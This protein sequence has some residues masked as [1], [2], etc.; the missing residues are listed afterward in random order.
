VVI[1]QKQDVNT[2]LVGTLKEGD[3]FGEMALL[4]QEGRTA[5][6]IATQ[7]CHL[8]AVDS[9]TFNV[10][11]ANMND[12]LVSF[13]AQVSVSDTRVNSRLERAPKARVL[14]HPEAEEDGA[15]RRSSTASKT[16]RTHPQLQ[17]GSHRS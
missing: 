7:D 6:I 2:K 1:K 14:S 15:S 4:Y 8:W 16:R 12:T 13:L 3:S 5:S 10:V 9:N 17:G 11:L